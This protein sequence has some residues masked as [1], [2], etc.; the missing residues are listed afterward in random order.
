VHSG[1]GLTRQGGSRDAWTGKMEETKSPIIQLSR[2]MA[3]TTAK[4][5]VLVDPVFKN[6]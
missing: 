4:V 2:E 6:R 1:V 5:R 3:V